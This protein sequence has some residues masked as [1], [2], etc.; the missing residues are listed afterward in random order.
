M[1]HIFPGMIDID[2]LLAHAPPQLSEGWVGWVSHQTLPM[3]TSQAD[4]VRPWARGR[5]RAGFVEWFPRTSK[6]PRE[7]SRYAVVSTATDGSGLPDKGWFLANAYVRRDQ[8]FDPQGQKAGCLYPQHL[9]ALY[10]RL[11]NLYWDERGGRR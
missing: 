7:G 5:A 8:H 1:I 3:P 10:H 2:A 4:K 11:E 9:R 6:Q